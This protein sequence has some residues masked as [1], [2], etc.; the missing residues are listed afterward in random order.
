VVDHDWGCGIIQRGSQKLIDKLE[1]DEITWSLYE[2][3]RGE[4][5]SVITEHEFLKLYDNAVI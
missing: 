2:E 5:L 4:I 3:K 1:L